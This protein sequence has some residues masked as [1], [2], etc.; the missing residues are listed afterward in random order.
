MIVEIGHRRARPANSMC[1]TL[2]EWR[3]VESKDGS[4][5]MEW[6]SMGRYPA[7]LKGAVSQLVEFAMNDGEETAGWREVLERLDSIAEAIAG[8]EER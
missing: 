2:E 8:L 7:T 1:Y 5:R 6:C 4:K 3:E